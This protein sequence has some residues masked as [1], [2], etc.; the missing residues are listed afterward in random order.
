MKHFYRSDAVGRKAMGAVMLALMAGGTMAQTVPDNSVPSTGLDIPAN[1]QIFGK[2][3]PNIRKP[4]AVVNE[5]VITGT[6]VDQRVALLAVANGT[7]LSPEDRDKLKLQILRQ[8]IDETLQIQEAKVSD[9]TITPEEIAQSFD[10]VA[11]NFGRTP[12]AMR[13]F[14]REAGSSERSLTRQIEAE[15]A[16]QRYL[17]R[18]IEPTTNVSDEEVKGILARLQEAK[19]TEEYNVKEIFLSATPANGQQVYANARQLVQEVQKGQQPF[20]YFAR[21]Y[22]E[23]TTKA[24]NGDL[25]WVRTAQLPDPLADALRTMQV[26]Q[27]AG[28]IELPGGFS[29]LYLTDKRQVLTADPRDARLSLKQLTMRFPAGTTQ[30]EATTRAAA[31]G[32]AT[33]A[34]QGCGSVEKVAAAIGAEVVDNDTVRIRDLPAQLQEIML[35]L[36]VG[37]S[38]PP[39]GSPQDGVRALVLCGRDDPKSGTLPRADQVQDQLE[40]Q[41]VNLRAQQKLR[42]LRRDAI[43][44]YR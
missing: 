33:Q 3:D 21:T 28:P 20:E 40:Q 10:R 5:T 11:K 38:S 19:G 44:D 41:R 34:L 30:A 32:R 1:L 17:R 22:S 29:L 13:T 39:F 18:K 2:L 31:F 43:I 36:Q 12:A 37:Q 9:I 42:D 8:L 7:A 16:W 6:D 15:L 4:T 26:G 23:A 35:K 25:G 27:V 24:V 14:L